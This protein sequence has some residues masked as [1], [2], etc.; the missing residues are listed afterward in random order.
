MDSS[1]RFVGELTTIARM[2]SGSACR[3]LYGG[4]VRSSLSSHILS[5]LCFQI[6]QVKWNKGVR[7]DG[8]DSIAHQ[9]NDENHWPDLHVP[10]RR[11][12]KVF[13]VTNFFFFFFFMIRY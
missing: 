5:E 8:V 1:H 12:D 10:T 13:S 9:L 6:H 7:E 4:W 2:G 3:S 11:R